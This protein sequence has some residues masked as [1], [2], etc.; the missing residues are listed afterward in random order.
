MESPK[1][2]Y[3]H[4]VSSTYQLVVSCWRRLRH[5][6]EEMINCKESSM[7]AHLID[8]LRLLQILLHGLICMP[9][10]PSSYVGDFLGMTF[11]KKLGGEVGK[12]NDFYQ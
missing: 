8:C 4:Q 9:H 5:G 3:A 7:P 6:S 12:D 1:H 2:K 10:R 11:L